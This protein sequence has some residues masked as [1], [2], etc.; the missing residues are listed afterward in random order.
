M[1]KKNRIKKALYLSSYSIEFGNSELVILGQLRLMSLV[2][3]MNMS[4]FPVREP[5]QNFLGQ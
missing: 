1:I 3:K 2:G 5:T 4:Y